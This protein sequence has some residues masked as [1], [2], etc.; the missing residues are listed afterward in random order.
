MRQIEKYVLWISIL[1]L[2]IAAASF[3]GVWSMFNSSSLETID[4]SSRI[5]EFSIQ[6]TFSF[7]PNIVGAFW[8]GW[9]AKTKGLGKLPWVLLSIAHGLIGI[10]LFYVLLCYFELRLIK[11]RISLNET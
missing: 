6:F 7:L 4:V 9:A 3:L 8:L 5:S 2:I 1:T 11:Q 10:I